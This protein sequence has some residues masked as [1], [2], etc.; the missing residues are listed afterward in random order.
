MALVSI[1]LA[2]GFL[3]GRLL[4]S[5]APRLKPI[6]MV[7]TVCGSY[8][9]VGGIAQCRI[10][11]PRMRSSAEVLVRVMSTGLDRTDL[12]SVSGWGRVER[13]KMHGGF[14]LGRD[15]CGVV[16]EVGEDV[17]HLQPGDRVWGAVPYNMPGTLSEML[18]LPGSFV[19]KMPNNLN[20][21]GAATVPYSALMVWNALVWKG[22]L[23]PE[24][25][26]GVR[27]LVIDGVT[28]T[29]CL[30]T[31]LACLWGCMVTVLCPARTVPLAHALGAHAVI[32]ARES[33][34][35]CV[36]DLQDSGPFN[37]I[38]LSGDLLSYSHCLPLLEEKGRICSTLPPQL[39]SDGWGFLRRF[40]LPSWR[41]LVLP[42]SLPRHRNLSQP[43]KYM[44]SAVESGKI[45]PVLDSVLSPAEIKTGLS[46]LAS[47]ETVGKSVVVFDKI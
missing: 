23:E 8:S 1:S 19:E 44:T 5:P 47:E 30:A 45:Q 26:D 34:E 39:S 37:L 11:V 17:P 4:S 9:G 32:G 40:L 24:K 28:D 36:H 29:G 27:V 35:E 22:K 14:T 43:L 25:S 20:W 38:V 12:L 46:R 41:T 42:P 31:Q 16:V 33:P 10:E 7:S 3:S 2:V 6:F 13:R 15:F 21:D 18:V